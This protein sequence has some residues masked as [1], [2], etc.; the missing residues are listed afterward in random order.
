MSSQ[1]QPSAGACWVRITSRNT[2]LQPNVKVGTVY[3]VQAVEETATGATVLVVESKD[4]KRGTMRI[5]DQRFGWEQVTITQLVQEKKEA[6]FRQAVKE[7]TERILHAFTVEEHMQITFVP[8]ILNEIA[9]HF[10]LKAMELGAAYRVQDLR[11]LSRVLKHELRDHYVRVVCKD[12]R[13]QDLY[14]LQAQAQEYMAEQSYNFQIM[15]FTACNVFTKQYGKVE[16]EDMRVYALL[17]M[18]IIRY[19]DE[20]N[21]RC[22]EMLRERLGKI[23]AAVRMPVMDKLYTGIACFLGELGEP[24]NFADSQLQMC[25]GILRNNLLK[26][27]WI[28]TNDNE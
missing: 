15:Y 25:M 13:P 12:L 21:K 24:F 6:K 19:T 22:D 17:C 14:R 16:F 10:A 4:T 3:H 18:A 8:L 7:D 5:N 26:Q 9:W 28:I 20:H 11:K 27:Q 23:Q 1:L 2:K